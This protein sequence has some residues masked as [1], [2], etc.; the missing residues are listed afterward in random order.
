MKGLSD[1]E[2]SEVKSLVKLLDDE[3]DSITVIAQKKLIEKGEVVLHHLN[4]DVI[5]AS[6][7]QKKKWNLSYNTVISTIIRELFREFKAKWGNELDLEEGAFLIARF[8]YPQTDMSS[9][10]DLLNYYAA[11]LD[12][13]LV[14][15]EDPVEIIARINTYFFENKGFSGNK[16]D[17][18]NKDNHFLNKVIEKKTGVPISLSVVYMLV[19]KR[20]NIPI[21][22]IGMPGHFIIKYSDGKSNIYIDPFESGKITTKDDCVKILS[23]AGYEFKDEYLE[24]VTNQQ[25]LERML[26]N[27]IISYER[28]GQ[29]EKLTQLLQYIDILNSNV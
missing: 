6:E 28:I 5:N 2:L 26:R 23:A 11:E 12:E 8:G 16:L 22:G 4:Q 21:K 15:I 29:E 1:S 10:S 18:Y 27:L 24:A 7:I 13:R 19:T 14:Q 20:L 9:Y 17:F 25:I 3:D